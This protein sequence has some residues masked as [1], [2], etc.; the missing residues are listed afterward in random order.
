MDIRNTIRRLPSRRYIHQCLKMLA[1]RNR[2]EIIKWVNVQRACIL[3]LNSSRAQWNTLTTFKRGDLHI[4]CDLHV[5]LRF[6]R[7]VR[8]PRQVQ[9][10]NPEPL[11]TMIQHVLADVV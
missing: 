1:S 7:R 2:V 8:S 10:S 4:E 6:W 11:I 3:M 9:T 5:E